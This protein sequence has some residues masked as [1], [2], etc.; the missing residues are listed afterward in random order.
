MKAINPAGQIPCL[1]HGDIALFESKALA[2]Y[3]DNFFPGPKF[4]PEESLPAE[5]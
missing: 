5:Q 1:R 3:I 4:L 2:T